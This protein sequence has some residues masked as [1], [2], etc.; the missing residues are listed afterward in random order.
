A[1][2][3]ETKTRLARGSGMDVAEIEP[4][5]LRVDLEERP[6]LERLR[7]HAVEVEVSAWTTA[8]LPRGRVPDAVDVRVLHRREDPLR[9]ARVE[10]A[11]ERRD[12]PVAG[13]EIS[14][15][16]VDAPVERD[17]D[18]D[19]TQDPER[20]QTL[21]QIRDLLGLALEAVVTEVVRMVGDGDVLVSTRLRGPR[22]LLEAVVGIGR[23][24]RVHVQVAAELIR[25]HETG[26]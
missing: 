18:L 19:A 14:L 9:R 20:R 1:G 22:H 8:D 3:D 11:V 13:G 26:Q 17:V 6:R 12:Y 15:G 4:V 2:D 23:P 25:L 21:V 10:R 24:G 16:H 7:D 5:G